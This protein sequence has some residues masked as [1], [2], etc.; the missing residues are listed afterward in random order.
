MAVRLMRDLSCTFSARDG[1]ATRIHPSAREIRGSFMHGPRETD[2]KGKANERRGAAVG[3]LGE[4]QFLDLG[5]DALPPP[6]SGR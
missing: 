5:V 6:L 1:C 2:L 4:G 3:V